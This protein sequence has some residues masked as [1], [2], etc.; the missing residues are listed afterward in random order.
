M[1]KI[2]Y[3]ISDRK[4][5]AID[6]RALV[7]R[8]G[9]L[10]RAGVDFIQV[11]EH[12]LA[13]RRLVA[14]TR[15]AVA[16]S[17]GTTARILVNGRADVA[18]AAGADGVHLRGDSYDARRLRAWTPP[19]FLVGRSVHTLD[20]AGAAERLGGCDFLLFGTIYPS[21]GKPAGHPT[22]GVDGLAAACHSVRMPVFAIGGIDI[23]RV[24]EV[25]A[26]GAAG[27]AAVDLFFRLDD[28]RDAAAR[29]TAT[30]HAFDS[31][32]PLV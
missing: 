23:A 6:E 16:A 5:L 32:S 9:W 30:R 19:G 17:R 8:I 20:E 29:V 1:R 11:R 7:R 2:L 31:G 28:E 18:V 14:L 12:D 26:A 25:A 13:D 15:D 10:A 3:A 22:A 4:R 27:I 24:P 21:R